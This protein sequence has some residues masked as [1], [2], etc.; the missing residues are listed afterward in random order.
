MADGCRCLAQL[1][2]SA[3]VEGNGDKNIKNLKAIDEADLAKIYQDVNFLSS[4]SL[5]TIKPLLK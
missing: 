1:W 4:K 5:D 2:V 3:W